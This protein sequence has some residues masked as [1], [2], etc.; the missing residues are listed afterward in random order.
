MR[1]SEFRCNSN[2]ARPKSGEILFAVVV[3]LA[4]GLSVAGQ[5]TS[6]ASRQIEQ[7]I[8]RIQDGILPPLVIQ[9]GGSAPP[10]L[11]QRMTALRVPGV[12]IAV[13][14][15]GKIEWARAFGVMKTGGPAVSPDTL[16]QTASTTKPA[17][18]LAI[19]RLAQSGKLNLDAD[20]NLYLR[21]WQV[22]AT[23]S[24]S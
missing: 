20:V 21:S 18:A 3:L 22:P 19:L 6:T 7:Q 14:R 1:H 24:T 10:T 9:N 17:S 4:A 23:G 16:F 13:I 11:A 12:S 5:T 8:Q 15:D 2:D